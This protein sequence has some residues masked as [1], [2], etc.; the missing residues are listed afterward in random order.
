MS[1]ADPEK[2]KQEIEPYLALRDEQMGVFTDSMLLRNTET[3]ACGLASCTYIEWS[4]R[5]Y[6]LSCHHVLAEQREYLAGAK[7]LSGGTIDEAGSQ[8]VAPLIPVQSDKGLDLALFDLNGLALPSIP[9][10][11]Y[12]LADS[13]LNLEKAQKN[14]RCVSFIH[15]APGFA[16]RGHQYPQDGLVFMQCPIY[17]AYGP[18]LEATDDVIVADFAEAELNE[19]NAE[20]FPHLRDFTPNGGTRNL[21]GMSGSGLWVI[22]DGRFKLLGVLLGLDLRNDPATQH[23]IRFTPIWQVTAWLESLDL[24]EGANDCEPCIHF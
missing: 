10:Q 16:T 4:G 13:Q 20:V 18:I 12:P 1:Q 22:C 19:L 9:K 5:A 21:S 7:R 8:E 11:A 14:L 23:L 15:A 17:S 2:I 24:D 6:A 3:G